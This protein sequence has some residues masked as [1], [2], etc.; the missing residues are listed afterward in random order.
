M[1]KFGIKAIVNDLEIASA[2]A[3]FTAMIPDIN[4][5]WHR[6]AASVMKI[7]IKQKISNGSS[8]VKYQ[9]FQKYSDSY[10]AVIRGD[11]SFRTTKTKPRRIYPTN[12]LDRRKFSRKSVTP[13]NLRLSGD[14]VKS[15]RSY[16]TRTGFY[17]RFQ[18]DKF[19]LHQYGAYLEEGRILPRRA[20]LPD[21]GE[22][23][24]D[25][26]MDKANRSLKQVADAYINKIL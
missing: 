8:P 22:Q 14:L 6:S 23:F 5:S 21:I 24:K 16:K 9:R 2:R 26:I 19:I 12:P 15:L 11:L 25:D 18:N 7:D 10:K 4:N 3:K 17:L 20:L 13:V 1:A